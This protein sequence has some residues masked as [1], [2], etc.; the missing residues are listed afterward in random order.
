MSLNSGVGETKLMMGGKK[1]YKKRH[2]AKNLLQ[3]DL[4]KVGC[5]FAN[6]SCSCY[7]IS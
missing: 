7:S 4:L 3:K 1:T 6:P 5:C 2:T